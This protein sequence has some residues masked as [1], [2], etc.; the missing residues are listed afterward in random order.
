MPL[1]SNEQRAAPRHTSPHPNLHAT[2]AFAGEPYYYS[3][4]VALFAPTEAHMDL[5]EVGGWE[6]LR[7]QRLCML[8]GRRRPALSRDASW[9]AG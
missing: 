3:V 1:Y 2:S 9:A 5:V 8:E 4:G 6:G 7:G